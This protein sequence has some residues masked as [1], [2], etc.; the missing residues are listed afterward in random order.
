M[1][2]NLFCDKGR[3]VKTLLHVYKCKKLNNSKQC[4]TATRRTSHN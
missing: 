3:R 4:S 1:P 2:V